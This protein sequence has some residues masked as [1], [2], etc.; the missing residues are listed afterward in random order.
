MRWTLFLGSLLAATPAWAARHE[1]SVEFHG[2]LH[3]SGDG[4]L[5]ADGE[6]AAGGIRGGYAVLKDR[7]R[8]GLVIGA[9][10]NRGTVGSTFD[11][12]G[13]TTGDRGS[14]LS[15]LTVD[16]ITVGL[17]GDVDVAN[18]FYPYVQ[19][20]AAVLVGTSFV[21]DDPS[22]DGNANELWASGA[23]G[24]GILTLGTEFMLPD[25]KLGWPVV[26]AFY[27][28]GGYQFASVLDLPDHGTS[29]DLSGAIFRAGVGLRF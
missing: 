26:P 3:D 5:H 22:R 13:G 21:D 2:N 18:V 14:V 17:K 9:G 20:Q 19:L 11:L 15:V 27:F 24:A 23:A 16:A 12:S 6:L 25:R 28:E 4:L 29:V 1:V 10:W 8:L 7:R